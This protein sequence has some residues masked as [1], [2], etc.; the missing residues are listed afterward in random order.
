MNMQY[1]MPEAEIFVKPA[2]LGLDILLIGTEI[3]FKVE[4]KLTQKVEDDAAPGSKK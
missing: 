2:P 4:A 3:N 1:W